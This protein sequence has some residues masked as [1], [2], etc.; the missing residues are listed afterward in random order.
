[1]NPGLILTHY[2]YY[3]ENSKEANIFLTNLKSLK[4]KFEYDS[5]YKYYIIAMGSIIEFLLERYCK[6]KSIKPE[7]YKGKVE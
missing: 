4:K 1:M 5:N 7:P 6:R 3:L 2:G